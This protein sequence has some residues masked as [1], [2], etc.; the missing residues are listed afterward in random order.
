VLGQRILQVLAAHP[1]GLSAEQ[2]RVY[3]APER[4]IGDI[5]S[6]MR[7]TGVVQVVGQ[8]RRRRYVL[9]EEK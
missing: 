7:R 3:V 4:P 6:G 9:A 8:G 2:I 1:D 5:L